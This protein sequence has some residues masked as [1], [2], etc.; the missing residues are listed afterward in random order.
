MVMPLTR[1]V[2]QA[3]RLWLVDCRS[4]VG[5]LVR[6]ATDRD[7]SRLRAMKRADSKSVGRLKERVSS[8]RTIWFGLSL[9]VSH[10]YALSPSQEA[11]LVGHEEE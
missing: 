7:L 11:A 8:G 5:P 10:W 1:M 3:E 4:T 2:S 9:G 6:N